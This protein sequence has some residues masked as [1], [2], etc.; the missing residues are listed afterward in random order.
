MSSDPQ[1]AS[2]AFPSNCP[3]AIAFPGILLFVY[4]NGYRYYSMLLRKKY[5]GWQAYLRNT[6]YAVTVPLASAAFVAALVAAATC[7]TRSI[8]HTLFFRAAYVLASLHGAACVALVWPETATVVGRLLTRI[9]QA[10]RIHYAYV[11][12]MTLCLAGIAVGLYQSVAMGFSSVWGLL[13]SLAVATGAAATISRFIDQ[14]PPKK[15]PASGL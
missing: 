10:F 4:S 15:P 14:Q 11:A 6:V 12:T 8:T 13:I 7:Q 1:G 5:A 3:F 9:R 2:S